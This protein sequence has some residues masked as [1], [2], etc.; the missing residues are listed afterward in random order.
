MQLEIGAVIDRYRLDSVLGRGGM[1][2]VYRAFDTRLRRPVALKVLH[3]SLT[4][5]AMSRLVREAR[6]AASLS[7]PNIVAVFDVGEHDGMPFMAMEL[8]E[9]QQLRHVL[10]APLS[11]QEKL[12][13][14]VDI[15]RGLDA[16]HR[17]GLVHRDVKPQNVMVTR[18]G[19][20][21]LDFGI[22]KELSLMGRNATALLP[23]MRTQ[24][25]FSMGTPQYMA[26]EVL[27]G[28]RDSDPRTDQ[29]SWGLVAYN[30][31]TGEVARRN[32]LEDGTP[33][34]A[35]RISAEEV[36]ER[37]AAIVA[38]TLVDSYAGRFASMGDVA[39]AL[40]ACAG[41]LPRTSAQGAARSSSP[42]RAAI[43]MPATTRALP[44][45]AAPSALAEGGRP[46]V[47]PAPSLPVSEPVGAAA[48]ARA[49]A[50]APAGPVAAGAVATAAPESVASPRFAP[51]RL[52][53]VQTSE[54]AAKSKSDA[55]AGRR[56]SKPAP[57]MPDAPA[58]LP[59]REPKRPVLQPLAD[60][61]VAE[62]VHAV[63][64][65]FRKAVVIVTLD[66][67]KQKA[68]FF[69]QL[70]ATDETGELWCPDASPELVRAAGAMIADDA[71]DGNGRWQRLVLRLQRGSRE[72]VVTDVQ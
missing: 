37:I 8:V 26:P 41:A 56:R 34:V 23:S 27:R 25:G 13:W 39:S 38:R 3:E 52:F 50:P 7:H 65:G 24:P 22:A 10:H 36:G 2:Q 49:P 42:M 45:D 32:D 60:A 66:L 1:G 28:E 58:T 48:P 11:L 35:P 55:P 71:R 19:A 63:P 68:R 21:I 31:L 72:A 62:L 4:A 46:P 43:A 61:A 64:V 15:A 20:K 17:A 47:P 5:E 44:L 67:E 54:P 12:S 59:I 29:F 30:V 51:T 40:E 6:L 14:L 16:A 69:V 70:V 53:A 33:W 18:S 57:P 9:G